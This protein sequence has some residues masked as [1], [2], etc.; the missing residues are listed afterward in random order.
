MSPA[1]APWRRPAGR[2]RLG[3]DQPGAGHRRAAPDP[4]RGQHLCGHPAGNGG[5]EKL[6]AGTLTLTGANTYT[7]GTLVSAGTLDTTGGGTWPTPAR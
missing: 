5:L 3:R 6:G 7:G 2:Q 4:E 1:T